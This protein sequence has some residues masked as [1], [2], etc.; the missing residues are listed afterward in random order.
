L[1]I[2]IVVLF[3]FDITQATTWYVHPDS[4]LNSIQAGLDS[5]AT[6]D[7]VL[8]TPATYVEN[9]IWP[10]VNGIKL[11]GSGMDSTIIN[12]NNQA[13]VLRFDDA[14]II[15]TTTIVRGFTLTNGNALPP[16]PQSLGGGICIFSS[17]PILESLQIIGNNA[18][19]YGGGISVWGSSSTPIIRYCIIADNTAIA[20]GGFDCRA[21]APILDHVTVSG[22]DPGGLYFNTAGYAQILNSIIAFNTYYG[23]RLEGISPQ[24]TFIAIGYSD[25]YDAVQVLGY[26][27]I[28]WLEG[29]I[30]TNPMFVDQGNSDFHLQSGSPCIDAGD[31]TYPYD[32]DST[33]TDMGAFYFH[34]T[35]IAERFLV[36]NIEQKHS[37][38]PTILNSPLMLPDDKTC[39]VFDITGRVVMPDK[40]KPG[41]YFI[42][43]DGKITQKVVKIK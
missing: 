27:G 11:I 35:S 19:D 30:D 24:A 12:G 13:S 6:N 21:G 7:T 34:Q 9:I 1:F 14:D 43:V 23:I 38:C 31:P 28:D 36:R 8:V 25:T 20:R 40:I 5:C 3:L 4:A 10:S 42:E 41:I 2:I 26:A 22:N 17:S 18:D 29:N 37:L 32:P 39:R 16:W 33:I 15:D